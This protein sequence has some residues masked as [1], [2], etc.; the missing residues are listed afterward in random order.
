MFTESVNNAILGNMAP[1]RHSAQDILEQGLGLLVGSL[2]ASWKVQLAEDDPGGDAYADAILDIS[3]PQGGVRAIVEV[4]PSFTPGDVPAV[5]RQANLLRRVTGG[6]PVVVMAPWLSDRSRRL[7]SEA[8]IHYL[9]LTGNIRFVT[10][11]PA[12]FIHR[13]S[14]A[15]APAHPEYMPAL[16]GVKAGRVV[17][18]L[19]DVQP[20]YGVADLARRAG[21]T[22]GYVSRLLEALATDGLIERAKRGTVSAVRWRELLERR[23]ESY[24]VFTS[25]RIRRFVCPNGPAYTLDAASD[26]ATPEFRTALTGSFA[27]E[28]IVAVAPPSLLVLYAQ[29]DATPLMQLARL[30]PAEAGANVVIAEPYDQV[31]A[32]ARWPEAQ[33]T[34]ARVPLVAASQI[35]LDCLTGNGRMPQEGE[36]LLDWMSQHEGEWRLSS[37]TELPVPQVVL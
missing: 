22:A 23:A 5:A 2:P 14:N 19:V 34:P 10:D 3:G 37:L 1:A 17:R 33:S 9:D 6:V 12:V 30:L 13:E 20:P 25:N 7:L 4:K 26:V 28:R 31:A 16:K 35:A 29:G 15:P 8:G 27:A 24:G 11:H 18:L 36:A 21:V 32:E